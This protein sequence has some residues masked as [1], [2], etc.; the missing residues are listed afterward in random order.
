M[1]H[2]PTNIKYIKVISLKDSNYADNMIQ[3]NCL[4]CGVGA[5]FKLVPHVMVTWLPALLIWICEISLLQQSRKEN[6]E[7]M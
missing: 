2:G 1:M 3:K 6:I 5:A 7:Q 4:P